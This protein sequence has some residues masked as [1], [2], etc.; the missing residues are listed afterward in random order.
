MNPR[1]HDFFGELNS[2]IRLR[3]ITQADVDKFITVKPDLTSAEIKT[4]PSAYFYDLIK[5]FL[6]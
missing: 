2:L 4:K 6:S 1:Y 3:K 5:A